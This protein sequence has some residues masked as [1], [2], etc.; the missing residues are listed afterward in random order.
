MKVKSIKLLREMEKEGHITL[1]PDTGSRVEDDRKNYWVWCIESPGMNKLWVF[2]FKG[3][4]YR[5]QYSSG[6]W[7]F[8][9]VFKCN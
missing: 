1:R 2:E 4:R 9:F 3:K 5:V 7:M 8:P 6:G